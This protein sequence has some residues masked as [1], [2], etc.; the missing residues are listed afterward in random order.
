[1]ESIVNFLT[2]QNAERIALAIVL[3]LFAGLAFC[4]FAFVYV[5]VLRFGLGDFDYAE[6]RCNCGR[7]QKNIRAENSEAKSE[8]E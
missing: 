7:K 8:R 5:A 6:K 1:M 4:L 3:G 2:P